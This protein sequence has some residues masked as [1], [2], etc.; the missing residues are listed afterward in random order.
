VGPPRLCGRM[1]SSVASWRVSSRRDCL[2][3]R[4]AGKQR[5]CQAQVADFT[6]AL[7]AGQGRIARPR[8]QPPGIA[9][10]G[11]QPPGA[12]RPSPRAEA[13]A[14]ARSAGAWARSVGA[15][16]RSV[17]ERARSAAARA[18]LARE[19]VRSAPARAR[20]V[21]APTRS[22]PAR[23]RLVREPARSL[24]SVLVRFPSVLVRPASVLVWG[25]NVGMHPPNE[26]VRLPRDP[27]HPPGGRSGQ[28]FD[29]ARGAGGVQRWPQPAQD[30]R[31]HSTE[32]FAGRQSA[33]CSG[34]CGGAAVAATILR[35]C[36]YV[37][38]PRLSGRS[39]PSRCRA[40]ARR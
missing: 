27:S 9:W 23:T 22:V 21:R 28:L 35:K 34:R 18:G 14:P 37:V 31:M 7:F 11:S 36:G 8:W 24:A 13:P 2:A 40:S 16:L 12:N 15:C 3:S 4:E 38:M 39:S 32:G 19:P 20:S 5:P 29:A 10:R 25:S 33:R 1:C 30:G 6:K 17:R 26:H